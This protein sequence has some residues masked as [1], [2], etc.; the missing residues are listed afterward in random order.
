MIAALLILTG[1]TLYFMTPAER[2]RSLRAALQIVRQM[3]TALE[4]RPHHDTASELVRARTPLVL[5]T[6]ALIALNAATFAVLLLQ[7]G[8]VGDPDTLVQW[9]GNFGPRTTNGEW[10]RLVTSTFVHAGMFRFLV[11]MAALAHLGLLLERLVGPSAFGLVYVTSGAV[12]SLISLSAHRVSVI[13]GAEGAV[14]GL[15]GLLIAVAVWGFIE[16][17]TLSIRL[18]AIARVIPTG[19]V[20]AVFNLT[21]GEIDKMT[22]LVALGVGG[23]TGLIVARGVGL[24]KPSPRRITVTLAATAATVVICAVPLRGVADIRPEISRIL[25]IE[26]RTAREYDKASRQFVLGAIKAEALARVIESSIVPTL[27]AARERLSGVDGV[28]SEQQ[29][30]AASAGEC[31]RLREEAWSARIGALRKGDMRKLRDADRLEWSA[32]AAFQR[33]RNFDNE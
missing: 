21:S 3:K 22:A 4:V 15:F 13:V 33:I 5:A 9:G 24:H 10:W 32:L 26:E 8:P 25:E 11:N 28:P 14:F 16:R 23:L 12:T 18:E 19:V 17:S 2:Q 31:L 20:F 29:A 30:L 27:R 6:P 1:C 7:A